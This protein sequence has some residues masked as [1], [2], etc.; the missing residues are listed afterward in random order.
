VEAGSEVAEWFNGGMAE[1][2]VVAS[3]EV[4]G[5]PLGIEDSDERPGW[6]GYG[7]MSASIRTLGRA[8]SRPGP[9]SLGAA[10][11]TPLVLELAPAWGAWASGAAR[12]GSRTESAAARPLT[13][14]STQEVRG[15]FQANS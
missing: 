9:Q 6:I 11:V 10:V 1:A 2:D 13:R 15:N 7:A 5:K 12:D 8:R 4:A 14:I 3:D